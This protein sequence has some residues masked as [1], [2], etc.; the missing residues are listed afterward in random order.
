MDMQARL[1]EDYITELT[2]M[3]VTLLKVDYF[4]EQTCKQRRGYFS[5][6]SYKELKYFEIHYVCRTLCFYFRL[7]FITLF[8]KKKY[9]LFSKYT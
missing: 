3:C 6:I 8:I 4:N 7:L 9:L 2:N 1:H 5:C